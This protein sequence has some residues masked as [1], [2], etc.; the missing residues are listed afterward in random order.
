MNINNISEEDAWNILVEEG[1]D[2]ILNITKDEFDLIKILNSSETSMSNA[3]I[4]SI[5]SAY[6]A[7][8]KY[9]NPSSDMVKSS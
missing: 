9:R 1:I 3:E 7:Y 4:A 5:L 2:K 6:K 8:K